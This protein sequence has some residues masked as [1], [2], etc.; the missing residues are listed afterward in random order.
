MD[1]DKQ[2][3]FIQIYA[4]NKIFLLPYIVI[5]VISLVF[6]IVF[7]REQSQIFINK[8]NSPFFDQFFKYLTYLGSGYFFVLVIFLVAVFRGRA[9]GGLIVAA[10]LSTILV[11]A[12]KHSIGGYRPYAFF[13]MYSDYSLHLV[14]GVKMLKLHSFPSGHTATA[15]AVFFYLAALTRRNL[16]KISYL[17]LAVLVGYSRVYLSQHFVV[18]VVGGSFIGILSSYI[19]LWWYYSVEKLKFGSKV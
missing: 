14:S 5:F 11:Q 2:N 12:L 3:S 9:S 17:L 19:G 10:I 16:L 7:G 15:F 8:L 13:Q 6:A 18:D 4:Q 1:R